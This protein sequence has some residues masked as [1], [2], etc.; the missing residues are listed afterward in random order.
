MIWGAFCGTV[1]SDPVYIPSKVKID[2]LT[3]VQT[4]LEP[5]LVPF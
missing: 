2:S 5:A 4:V 3:Y 1:K